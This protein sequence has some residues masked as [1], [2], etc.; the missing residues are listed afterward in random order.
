MLVFSVNLV[1]FGTWTR[2]LDILWFRWFC[3]TSSGKPLAKEGVLTRDLALR[4]TAP[5][6]LGCNLQP[7]LP[8]FRRGGFGTGPQHWAPALSVGIGFSFSL[9]QI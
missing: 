2:I 6:G 9:I 7:H 1:G 3:F 5:I 4:L 8:T